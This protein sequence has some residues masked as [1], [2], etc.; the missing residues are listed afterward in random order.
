V[1]IEERTEE[2]MNFRKE[3][4]DLEVKEGIRVENLI[5]AKANN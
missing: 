1:S 4:N 5:Q 3:L 2:A